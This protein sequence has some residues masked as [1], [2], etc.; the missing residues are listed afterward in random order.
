MRGCRHHAAHS[1]QKIYARKHRRMRRRPEQH[2]SEPLVPISAYLMLLILMTAM[3]S[4]A[5]F[6]SSSEKPPSVRVFSA[7]EWRT[8]RSSSP[9][10]AADAQPRRRHAVPRNR[11]DEGQT[12]INLATL[13]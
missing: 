12:A 5:A 8:P 11:D 6:I 9:I 3:A 4:V 7:E 10:K 2:V 1:L 13:E